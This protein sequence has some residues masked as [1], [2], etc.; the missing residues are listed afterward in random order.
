MT[1]TCLHHSQLEVLP[2]KNTPVSTHQRTVPHTP[3]NRHSCQKHEH[4]KS[5]SIP[6]QYKPIHNKSETGVKKSCPLHKKKKIKDPDGLP[7]VT[8]HLIKTY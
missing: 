3:D 4:K 1:S 5:V 6:A 7:Y 2:D 8:D